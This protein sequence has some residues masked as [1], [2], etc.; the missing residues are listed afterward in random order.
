[1][2][3]MGKKEERKRTGMYAPPTSMKS[4]TDKIW[5]QVKKKKKTP[6]D[7]HD[8]VKVKRTS[9]PNEKLLV[10]SRENRAAQ[11]KSAFILI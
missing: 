5:R 2:E 6:L 11:L 10:R 7:F 9:E 3:V 1:M 8:R 4:D